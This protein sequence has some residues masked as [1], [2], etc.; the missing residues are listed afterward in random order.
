[1]ENEE[2]ENDVPFQL[3]LEF[4]TSGVELYRVVL[5]YNK[6]INF[7]SEWFEESDARLLFDVLIEYFGRLE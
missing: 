4:T 2:V 1:M 5:V 6:K 7:Y 3:K